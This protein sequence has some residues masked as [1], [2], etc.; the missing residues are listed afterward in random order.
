MKNEKKKI[1]LLESLD[2]VYNVNKS[3]YLENARN[4]N[5]GSSRTEIW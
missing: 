2:L 3:T 1:L 4:G 5:F